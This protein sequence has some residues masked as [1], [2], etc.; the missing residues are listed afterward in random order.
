MAIGLGPAAVL[1]GWFYVRI[2]LLYGDFGA[3]TF[4]FEHFDRVARR[5]THMFTQGRWWSDLTIG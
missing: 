3:S 2:H 1:F 4:L 5:I